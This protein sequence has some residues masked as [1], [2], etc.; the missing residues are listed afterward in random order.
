MTGTRCT[1]AHDLDRVHHVVRV[2]VI[3]LPQC[4]GPRKISGHLIEH[5]L[6]RSERLDARIP[7]LLLGG[8]G[9]WAG[10][11]RRV[12]RDPPV[13]RGD[14]VRIGRAGQYLRDELV[15]IERDGRD[16]LV[17]LLGARRHVGRCCR[18]RDCL[19]NNSWCRRFDRRCGRHHWR[20]GRCRCAA[21]PVATG[22]HQHRDTKYGDCAFCEFGKAWRSLGH[23]TPSEVRCAPRST[24][25]VACSPTRDVTVRIGGDCR[26]RPSFQ[27]LCIPFQYRQR[28]FTAPPPGAPGGLACCS[29]RSSCRR[30]AR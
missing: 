11:E 12:L 25:T 10:F 30:K 4:S 1:L 22:Q 5:A 8:I 26:S 15:R 20:R 6:E 13:G 3:S 23:E 27:R 18:R 16:H 14:L 28:S 24:L 17:E 21:D 2:V 7:G 29:I 9:Q 19:G